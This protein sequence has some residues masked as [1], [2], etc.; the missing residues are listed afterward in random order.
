M[1][2][3]PSDV[4]KEYLEVIENLL[5]HKFIESL[6]EEDIVEGKDYSIELPYLGSF[7]V[8]IT[9]KGRITTSFTAK[10]SFYKKIKSAYLTRESPLVSQCG[11]ILGKD[12]ADKYIIEEGSAL[13]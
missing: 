6:N 11:T 7:T 5:I 2:G 4:S 9:D 12:L 3:V 8:F 13:E 10:S 1:L